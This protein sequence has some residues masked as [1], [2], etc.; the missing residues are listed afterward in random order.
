MNFSDTQEDYTSLP[1]KLTLGDTYE[2]RGLRETPTV[3]TR[4]MEVDALPDVRSIAMSIVADA[5]QAQAK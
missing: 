5:N 1:F 3:A 4:A 2:E